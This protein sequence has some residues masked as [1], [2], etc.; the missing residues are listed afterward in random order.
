MNQ[1]FGSLLESKEGA[2]VTFHLNKETFVAHKA[3]LAA[4][5]PVFRAQF[6]GS[7]MESKTDT[8][9]IEEMKPEV[10]KAMLHFI[11]TETLP[12][13]E[14]ISFEMAQH[15]LV[16]ADRYGLERL[17]AI[18][19]KILCA[20]I[21]AKT[22]VT[23]LAFAVRHSCPQ[24]KAFC[25]NFVASREMLESFMASNEFEHLVSSYPSVLK[26]ILEKVK[27]VIV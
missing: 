2:D 22:A 19:A 3:V 25:V 4:R 1:H 13:Q 5:S 16:A 27:K 21:D 8:V 18:C 15:L 6:F 14:D 12:P 26:E 20:G 11:Y 10:F 17:K 24:L 9:E 7:M 23:T